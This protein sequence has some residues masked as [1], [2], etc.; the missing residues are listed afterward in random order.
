MSRIPFPRVKAAREALKEKA[1]EIYEEYKALA[2]KAADAGEFAVAEKVLWNLIEHMPAEEG[3]HLIDPSAAKSN[4]T[5][6]PMQPS[7]KIGIALGGIKDDTK[8]LPEV[9]E[10][11]IPKEKL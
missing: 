10:I 4:Q 3:E 9:T 2:A 11:I 7:I 6:L 5:N 1:L 8:A